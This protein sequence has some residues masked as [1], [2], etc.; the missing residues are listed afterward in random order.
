MF[1]LVRAFTAHA[2]DVVAEAVLHPR[3]AARGTIPHR[4]E[5]PSRLSPFLPALRQVRHASMMPHLPLAVRRT[6]HPWCSGLFNGISGT[7][8]PVFRWA[9]C[10]KALT[11]PVERHHSLSRRQG[12]FQVTV[13][14]S[15]AELQPLGR[16]IFTT[17]LLP[18]D[19]ADHRLHL[20]ADGP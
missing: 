6:T 4:M 3:V 11:C 2:I 8:Q 10:C 15:G 7:G 13:G 14:E 1:K 9:T 18:F 12:S 5:F 19:G 17:A 16:Q 20:G